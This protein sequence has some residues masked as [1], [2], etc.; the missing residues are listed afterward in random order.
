[1]KPKHI[2]LI[3][4]LALII[5]L[6]NCEERTNDNPFDPECEIDWSPGNFQVTQ[7]GNSIK[8]TW[9]Q[10]IRNIS[11]FKILKS[12]DNGS[13]KEL[14]PINKN[15]FSYLDSDIQGG[16]LY[17]Y[18]LFAYADQ[19][20][21]TIKSAQITPIM[22]ATVTTLVPESITSNSAICGGK[23]ENDGGAT[24]NERGICYGTSPSP[25]ISSN[26]IEMGSGIGAFKTTVSSL[27]GSTKYYVRAYAINSQGTAYGTNKEFTTGEVATVISNSATSLTCYSATLNGNISSDNSV[28]IS[29]RGF[30]WSKTDNPDAGDNKKIVNGTIGNYSIE[31]SNLQKNT[32]YYFR[33]YAIVNSSIVPG[34]VLTFTTTCSNIPPTI[35]TNNITGIT[36]N[37]ANSGGQVTDE[38]SSPVIIRGVCWSTSQNPT[39]SNSKTSNG[40]GPGSFSSYITGLNSC[41]TYYVRAYATNNDG[42]TG[43]GEQK[44]FTTIGCI[45]NPNVTTNPGDHVTCNSA[46]LNGTVNS[47]G[48]GTITERGFYYGTSSGSLTNKKTVTGTTGSFSANLSGLQ[49]NTT[50]Y[51]RAYAKNS[52][53]TGYGSVRSFTP[54][55]I[56]LPSVD[57]PTISNITPTTATLSSNVTSDGD[58][59]V[60]VR[61]FVWTTSPTITMSEKHSPTPEGTGTGPFS[62]NIS[63]LSPETTYYVWAYATNSEGTSYSI[64]ANF[65]TPP[66]QNIPPTVT[67]LSANISGTTLTVS[68]RIDS[69]G[70]SSITERGF[71]FG[72]NGTWFE[73]KKVHTTNNPFSIS[74]DISGADPGPGTY[75]CQAYAVNS[76]GKTYGNSVSFT[77]EEQISNDFYISNASVS[78]TTVTPGERISLSCDQHYVGNSSETLYPYVGYYLSTNS[79]WDNGDELIFHDES[80]L[81]TSDRSDSESVNYN[82]SSSLSPGTYYV[83]FKA[84]YKEEYSETNEN[85]NVEAVQITVEDALTTRTFTAT[86][87]AYI[88]QDIPDNTFNDASLAVA[89]D[90]YS[91]VR[92]SL[93]SVPSSADIQSATLK[94]YVTSAFNKSF[95]LYR[96]QV[97]DSWSESSISWNYQPSVGTTSYSKSFSFS[98]QSPYT[99]IEMDM[100][101]FV[102]NWIE[103][104]N[105]NWGIRISSNNVGMFNSSES[106][107]NKPQLVITYQ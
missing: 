80:T 42:L 67:T 77:I 74:D 44:T 104:G 49:E 86:A 68:G 16:K 72:Q 91:F 2:H 22:P 32:T 55:C 38:G 6:F 3:P 66:E 92:F 75:E 47:G 46:R 65:T 40:N 48:G 82:L 30:F 43:Y 14:Q 107:S 58:A 73:D 24:I 94:L 56:S 85:N 25:T 39:I 28:L 31:I 51:F 18:Q 103:K 45:D 62:K 99:W 101:Q 5:F 89:N 41:T 61:S 64:R 21:S 17:N 84:D 13:P 98:T 102:I 60:T 34:E 87:D 20:E 33:A 78:P 57:K 10:E 50:Y 106:S 19:Y 76:V 97:L 53:G 88:A 37:S 4:L 71:R 81:S 52:S 1:M 8:L 15:Q 7:N 100:T 79:T 26:K 23:V 29:E 27:S 36:S 83:L 95:T 35:S 93:S 9:Y 96:R 69:E 63:G 105:D 90:I 12:M 54:S 59:S 70:S 11:G